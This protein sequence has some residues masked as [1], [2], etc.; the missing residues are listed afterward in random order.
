MKTE[1]VIV[2]QHDRF[3]MRPLDLH[4]LLRALVMDSERVNCIYLGTSATQDY[5]HRTR[6]GRFRCKDGSPV[7]LLDHARN[8]E[9]CGLSEPGLLPMLIWLDSTHIARTDWY[10]DYVFG[11][12][13]ALVA[14][15]GFIEDKFGQQ[16][17]LWL[18]A[19]GL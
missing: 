9:G 10:R 8:P 1:Y 14:K 7:E 16:Q 17:A 5:A 3:F 2:V 13:P 19:E 18:D 4:P 15:G 12:P 6:S 11:G